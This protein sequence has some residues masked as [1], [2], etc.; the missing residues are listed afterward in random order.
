M[1]CGFS[2]GPSIRTSLTQ[3]R[4][5]CF[6]RQ[7]DRSHARFKQIPVEGVILV[8]LGLTLASSA[9]NIAEGK[10]R[11]LVKDVQSLLRNS[12][13]SW[14]YNT[15]FHRLELR[16]GAFACVGCVIPYGKQDPEVLRWISIKNLPEL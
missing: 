8:I 4:H 9:S 3:S 14:S 6:Q 13:I 10:R 2:G 1:D 12:T 7:G 16:R 11:K 15:C 5:T